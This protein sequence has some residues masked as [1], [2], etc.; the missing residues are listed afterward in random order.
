MSCFGGLSPVLN[1]I[2]AVLRLHC[3]R[4]VCAPSGSGQESYDQYALGPG[5]GPAGTD[6]DQ[7]SPL[8][9]SESVMGGEH[10]HLNGNGSV[11]PKQF[12][13]GQDK[14][15]SRK[16]GNPINSLP[17]SMCE[18]AYF[19]DIGG[20]N[21]KQFVRGLERGSGGANGKSGSLCMVLG[22]GGVANKQSYFRASRLCVRV[23][24]QLH[25]I[26]A[27]AGHAKGV[28]PCCLYSGCSRADNF[29]VAN[30]SRLSCPMV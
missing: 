5:M 3:G 16:S 23:S 21:P 10:V 28:S 8:D 25:C 11:N 17:S 18:I 1:S 12:V 26:S 9:A 22:Q 20:A 27:A 7:D 2:G 19:N 30:A 14:R 29:I 24:L 6:G 13:R 15:V 4:I